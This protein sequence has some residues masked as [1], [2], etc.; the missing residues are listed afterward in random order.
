MIYREVLIAGDLS[1][2]DVDRAT[3]QLGAFQ[4]SL[5]QMYLTFHILIPPYQDFAR[6]WTLLPYGRSAPDTAEFVYG[7]DN[8]Y[9]AQPSLSQFIPG[10]SGAGTFNT[11]QSSSAGLRN[12]PND[13]LVLTGRNPPKDGAGALVRYGSPVSGVVRRLDIRPFL[14][15]R[16]GEPGFVARSSPTP[17]STCSAT[18]LAFLYSIR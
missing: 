1:Q 7:N 6:T 12:T 3:N 18:N 9:F 13:T 11:N 5:R 2:D 15:T 4:V 10:G 16:N 14:D 8:I 17:K